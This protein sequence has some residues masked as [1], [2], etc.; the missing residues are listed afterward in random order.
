VLLHA[1]KRRR[2]IKVKCSPPLPL[3]DRPHRLAG[4]PSEGADLSFPGEPLACEV[5]MLQGVLVSLGSPATGPMHPADAMP[6]HRRR[7]AL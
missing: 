6:P 3:L 5:P 2:S 7:S 4:H 1:Q